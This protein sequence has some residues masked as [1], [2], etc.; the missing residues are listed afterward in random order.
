MKYALKGKHNFHSEGVEKL[1]AY[2]DMIQSLIYE[3]SENKDILNSLTNIYKDINNELIDR[4]NDFEDITE[5]N[6]NTFFKIK[7]RKRLTINL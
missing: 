3:Y 4:N 7:S 2:K 5:E 6:K 1:K